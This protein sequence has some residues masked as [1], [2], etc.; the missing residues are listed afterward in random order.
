[1]TERVFDALALV[2]LLGIL[3]GQHDEMPAFVSTGAN[4]LAVIAFVILSLMIYA[5]F[6][7]NQI[8]RFAK[9]I[10]TAVV[11]RKHPKL[12]D[13]LLHMLD[14]FLAGLRAISSF[15]ELAFVIFWTAALWLTFVLLYQ[16]GLWAFGLTPSWWTGAS[17]S[18][19][20]WTSSST[21]S[22]P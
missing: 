14:G 15:K 4:A 9:R 19:F 2:A 12:A 21:W 5:Y 10:V 3:L 8:S 1:M 16:C 7:S 18:C 22:T 6:C 11:G 20:W 13:K 17:T